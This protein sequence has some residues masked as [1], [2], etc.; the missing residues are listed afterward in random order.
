MAEMNSPE[1]QVKMMAVVRKYFPNVGSGDVVTIQSS[2]ISVQC[3]EELMA[4]LREAQ[5]ERETE[6]QGEAE[7]RMDEEGGGSEGQT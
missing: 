7:A 2:D 4:I 3:A 5:K 1:A 6:D